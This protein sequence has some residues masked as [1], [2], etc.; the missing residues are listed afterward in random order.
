MVKFEPQNMGDLVKEYKDITF[1]ELAELLSGSC[2][3]AVIN[4]QVTFIAG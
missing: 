2:V 4:T 1:P 3:V